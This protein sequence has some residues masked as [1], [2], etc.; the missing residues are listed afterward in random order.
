MKRKYWLQSRTYHSLEVIEEQKL[1]E[2]Y[3]Q[4]DIE[5]LSNK[6][7]YHVE[8]NKGSWATPDELEQPFKPEIKEVLEYL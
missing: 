7:I 6:L 4:E 3:P 1:H 2:P 8:E 5:P